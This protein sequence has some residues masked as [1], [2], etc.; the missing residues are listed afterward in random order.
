[1]LSVNNDAILVVTHLSVEPTRD[2][3]IL[4]QM[5]KY[6]VLGEVVHRNNVDVCP[7]GQ[8]GSK[9]VAAYATKPINS[10]LNRQLRLQFSVMYPV[11]AVSRVIAIG[12]V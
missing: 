5:G 7:L 1:V 4:Q 12:L 2:G 3:V 6:L 9:V 10:N 8:S 11:R